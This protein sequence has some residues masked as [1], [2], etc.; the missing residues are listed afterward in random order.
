MYYYVVLLILCWIKLVFECILCDLICFLLILIDV[1]LIF[2]FRLLYSY[3]FN[4][5]IFCGVFSS[6]KLFKKSYILSGEICLFMTAKT[7]SPV[8]FNSE[9]IYKTFFCDGVCVIDLDFPT[10]L[11]Y[12]FRW[13]CR[14]R[15]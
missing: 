4:R 6:V 9:K 11:L 15:R 8:L 12:F 1:A 7:N 13:Y 14:G 5:V 10:N 2:L 3:M